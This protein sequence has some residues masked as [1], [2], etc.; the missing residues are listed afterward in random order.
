MANPSIFA[1]FERMWQHL[2]NKLGDQSTELRDYTD[3]RI[4]D[5]V[6][7]APETLDT[8]GELA[9]AMEENADVVEALDAAISTK[10][11]A[12]A[13]TEHIN[14]TSSHITS[15]ERTAWNASEDNAKAYVD[16]SLS[17]SLPLIIDV[18][19]TTT[20]AGTTFSI[21]EEYT[22]EEMKRYWNEDRVVMLRFNNILYVCCAANDSLVRFDAIYESYYNSSAS[23]VGSYFSL[24]SSNVLGYGS[25]VMK[26]P[27]YIRFYNSD[28]ANHLDGYT[29]DDINTMVDN[30]LP[31][32]LY[33]VFTGNVKYIYHFHKKTVDANGVISLTFYYQDSINLYQAVLKSDGSFSN[34]YYGLVIGSRTVNGKALSSNITLTAEDVGV[35]ASN[36]N[37]NEDSSLAYIKN[38]PFYESDS[39]TVGSY[40]GGYIQAGSNGIKTA[41]LYDVDL[42]MLEPGA[43]YH[44]T[45]LEQDPPYAEIASYDWVVKEWDS[46]SNDPYYVGNPIIYADSGSLGE[47][48]GEPAVLYTRDGVVYMAIDTRRDPLT[49]ITGILNVVISKEAGLKTLDEKYI[50]D[51]IART[52]HTHNW[53]DVGSKAYECNGYVIV[54]PTTFESNGDY[55]ENV[56]NTFEIINGEVY[57]V[58][59]DGVEYTTTAVGDG[60]DITDVFGVGNGYDNTNYTY[61]AAG[62]HTVSIYKGYVQATICE[63]VIIYPYDNYDDIEWFETDVL[64]SDG[65][66]YVV[67]WDDVEY[68][69]L[70]RR[71][72]ESVFIGRQSLMKE[73]GYS[74]NL[75]DIGNEP[76]AIYTTDSGDLGVLR[77]NQSHTVTVKRATK[78]V[79]Y[80]MPVRYL[81]A[82]THTIEDVFEL[83][84]NKEIM[85][86]ENTATLRSGDLEQYSDWME[87]SVLPSHGDTCIV[88]WQGEEYETVA[89]LE[90]ARGRIYVGNRHFYSDAE[91]TGEP[92]LF[93][94][95]AEDYE[96]RIYTHDELT[97]CTYK[98]WVQRK[99]IHPKYIPDTI[100]RKSDLANAMPSVTTAD[101]GKFLRVVDGVWAATTVP[102]AE[103]LEV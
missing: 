81:P 48:S 31:V 21:P 85:L 19:S 34:G 77:N 41:R 60:I 13:L 49:A 5:L 99:A 51:S 57:T 100:A 50:P 82:H 29:F 28:G 35:E 14:D 73:H 80:F 10:A 8:L 76:F 1:A 87:I 33:R 102:R 22:F 9:T 47:D 89:Y 30:N 2:V 56:F 42:T 74:G 24:N 72:G 94:I 58:L 75:L 36:W 65:E 84:V 12:S 11:N 38:R 64:M 53:M 25:N 18:T 52:G 101:N 103:D 16:E 43:T 63:D 45:F 78:R 62:T 97:E 6:N 68:I 37:I 91:D 61:C 27:T 46:T 93:L 40:L 26:H 17:S 96:Y 79:D 44:I 95:D 67:T 32:F 71:D 23:V 54:E 15:A 83:G 86:E 66:T 3:T 88:T 55:M 39:C 70:A 20:D 59:F 92:F 69:C 7:S 4:A 98:A 90:E